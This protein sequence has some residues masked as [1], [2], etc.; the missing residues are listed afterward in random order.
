MNHN[1]QHFSQSSAAAY[2]P[3]P[4]STAPGPY[5]TAPPA[6]YPMSKDEYSQQNP[7]AVET[8][9]RGDGFWKGCCAALCCCCVLDACF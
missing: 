4:P 6:G 9:S 2:A 1:Q 7:A 8:K 5:V 3:P